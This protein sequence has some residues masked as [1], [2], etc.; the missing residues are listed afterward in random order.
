MTP[1]HIWKELIWAYLLGYIEDNKYAPT[2]FEIAQEMDYKHGKRV[3]E[4]RIRQLLQEMVADGLITIEF[5]KTR[6]IRINTDQH[7]Q[8]R[9]NVEDSRR[10]GGSLHSNSEIREQ[11]DAGGGSAAVEP[12]LPVLRD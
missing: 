6:G 9:G 4:E 7:G 2:L 12:P 8:V 1:I 10:N 11:G 3:T 5:K